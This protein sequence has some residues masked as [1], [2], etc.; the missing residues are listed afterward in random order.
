MRTH[1]HYYII[2]T[3]N[4]S[5]VPWNVESPPVR[6]SA[7]APHLRYDVPRNVAT[8]LLPLTPQTGSTYLLAAT[9]LADAF[10]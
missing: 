10:S 3:L 4:C 5:D 9:S 7:V 1:V 6:P 8:P 2:G